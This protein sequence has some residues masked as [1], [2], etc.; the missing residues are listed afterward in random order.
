MKN[1]KGNINAT[2]L[3]E[4]DRRVLRAY[5]KSYTNFIESN[6]ASNDMLEKNTSGKTEKDQKTL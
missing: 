3:N 6:T 4:G 5:T 1:E 2:R